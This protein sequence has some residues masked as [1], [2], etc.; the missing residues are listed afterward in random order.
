MGSKL[1]SKLGS[2]MG[3]KLCS[4]LGS[5]FL[6]KTRTGGSSRKKKRKEELPNIHMKLHHLCV[7]VKSV[8]E[9]K[10]GRRAVCACTWVFTVVVWRSMGR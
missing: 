2:K 4:K 9:Q 6:L 7:D 1:G 5:R 10:K 8:E 3:S